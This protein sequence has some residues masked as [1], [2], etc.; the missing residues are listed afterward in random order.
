MDFVVGEQLTFFLG[1]E[2]FFFAGDDD[3][4]FLALGFAADAPASSKLLNPASDLLSS[5]SASLAPEA[6]WRGRHGQ[7]LVP[8]LMQLTTYLA[9]GF[10]FSFFRLLLLLLDLFIRLLSLCAGLALRL[11][12][13]SLLLHWR[14]ILLVVLRCSILGDSLV[15][16]SGVS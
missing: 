11:A 9:L 6:S 7:F 12:S 15:L 5:S 13:F 1:A 4:P 14:L 16:S 2:A 8:A 3:L 10:R